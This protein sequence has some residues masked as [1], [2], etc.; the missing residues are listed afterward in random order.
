VGWHP[1]GH[2]IGS[3]RGF[4]TKAPTKIAVLS[5]GYYHG[6]GVDRYIADKSLFGF[7]R[8]RRKASFVK[9]NGKNARVLGSVGLMHTM[10][11]VT[12]IDCTVGDIALLDVDPV[13][14]K[15]LPIVYR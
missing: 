9:I 4:V 3:E 6:F 1:K 2:T 15:G 10:V 12:K 8:W 11:D 5:I 13:N 7:L 14:V